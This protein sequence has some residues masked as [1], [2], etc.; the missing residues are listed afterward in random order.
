M[1]KVGQLIRL[2]EDDPDIWEVLRVTECSATIRCTGKVHKE[3]ETCN[4]DTVSFDSPGRRMTV[5]PNSVVEVVNGQEED[6]RAADSGNETGNYCRIESGEDC[7]EAFPCD[8][9]SSDESA[10]PDEA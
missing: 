1:L 8:S 2:T 5:S 9:S 3:F 7:E 4:G 10:Y 6:V